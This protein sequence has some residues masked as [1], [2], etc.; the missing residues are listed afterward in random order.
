MI[1][2]IHFKTTTVRIAFAK[3]VVDDICFGYF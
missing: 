1:N 3:E 2:Y